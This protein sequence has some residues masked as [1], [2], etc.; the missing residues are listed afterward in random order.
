MRI[1][2]TGS[3]GFIGS[4]LLPKLKELNHEV[5][6]V[7]RSLG[8][9]ISNWKSISD[10]PHCEVI[11]HLAARTFVPD[12]FDNP[13]EFYTFNIQATINTLELARIWNAKI[14]YMSSYLYGSPQY[15]PV[16][17][18]HPLNPHNPYAQTKYLSEE[19]CKGYSRDFDITVIVF[20][21]FNV[22]GPGQKGSFL[23][24]EILN[25]IKNGSTITLKDPRP[26]R[27]Y[28]HVNDV[29]SAIIMAIGEYNIGFDVFN[30]ASGK[31][32]AVDELVFSIVK[33]SG[34]KLKVEFTNE[35]RKGEVLETVADLKKIISKLNWVPQTTLIE[36]ITSLL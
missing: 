29:V 35:F 5:I 34:K 32:V 11:V 22:Y 15:L 27:D 21:L 33:L 36:G 9:D 12:S 7:S 23:I 4:H 14:I 2:V 19:L 8:Y 31:S 20:R 6:E 25:K 30:L 17:E 3:S 13:R 28:I 10:L 24:P 18:K 26:K 1:A 16:D